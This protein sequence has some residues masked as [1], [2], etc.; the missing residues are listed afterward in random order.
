MVKHQITGS[1][2]ANRI[3]YHKQEHQEISEIEENDETSPEKNP[4]VETEKSTEKKI[5]VISPFPSED[6]GSAYEKPDK[7]YYSCF[8]SR[9]DRQHTTE[10]SASKENR[11]IP[12]DILNRIRTSK[13]N[14]RQKTVQRSLE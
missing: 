6:I 1:F 14:T 8:M 5:T 12:I 2:G 13:S 7:P 3:N 11:I 10:G 9:E 4:F